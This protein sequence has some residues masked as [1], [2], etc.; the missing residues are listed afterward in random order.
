MDE[1][2]LDDVNIFESFD[3]E[4]LKFDRIEKKFSER[5]DLHAFILLSQLVPGTSDIVSS[6]EHDEIYLDTD[7]DELIKV[8]TNE[9]LRDLVRCGV[10][11]DSEFNCLCMFV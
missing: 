10:R 8:A 2:E 4:F 3:D 1:E 11:Y 7:V 9:Q 6:A 5:S